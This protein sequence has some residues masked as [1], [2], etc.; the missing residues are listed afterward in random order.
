MFELCYTS[1]PKGLAPGSSGYTTVGQSPQMRIMHVKEA[2]R[3][4]SFQF[5]NV[6]DPRAF[7]REPVNYIHLQLTI[8]KQKVHIVSRIAACQPDHTGRSNY[9]AHHTL[10][11]RQEAQPCTAG[12]AQLAAS[13]AFLMTEWTGDARILPPR[14]LP[15][16]S[17]QG[18]TDNAIKAAGLDPGWGPVLADRLCDRGIKQTYLVY[19]LG[20]DMLGIVVDVL[21]NLTPEE[22]WQATF[23][24][25][26]TKTFPPLGFDCRLRC[27][28]ADT[29]YAKEVL[30]RFPKDTIDLSKHP[31]APP[32][33]KRSTIEFDDEQVRPTTSDKRKRVVPDGH[34]TITPP[35]PTTDGHWHQPEGKVTIPSTVLPP[36]IPQQLNGADRRGQF[37]LGAILIPSVLFLLMSIACVLLGYKWMQEKNLYTKSNQQVSRLEKKNGELE[38]ESR[39]QL[40][41]IKQLKESREQL[42][43]KLKEPPEQPEEPENKSAETKKTKTTKQ[44]DPS[45]HDEEPQPEKTL[46]KVEKTLPKV[47]PK[48]TSDI[49]DDNDTAHSDKPVTDN[50]PQVHKSFHDD[51]K[52][53]LNGEMKKKT[54]I[55]LFE[56]VDKPSAVTVTSTYDDIKIKAVGNKHEISVK[57]D[58]KSL[59]ICNIACDENISVEMSEKGKPY[60]A[61]FV[62]LNFKFKD[63]RE[64]T[65]PL[66]SP[67]DSLLYVDLPDGS[68]KDDAYLTNEQSYKL[69]KDKEVNDL[70]SSLQADFQ[71]YNREILV[72]SFEFDTS[73]PSCSYVDP[74]ETSYSNHAQF[75]FKTPRKAVPAYSIG[76]GFKNRDG[77]EYEVSSFLIDPISYTGFG[78][79]D[80]ELK[81]KT[82]FTEGQ[83]KAMTNV[84][85]K[86]E[87]LIQKKQ[88]KLLSMGLTVG[89]KTRTVR[90]KD[91]NDWNENTAKSTKLQDA[92]NTD[93]AAFADAQSFPLSNFRNKKVR[94]TL[95]VPDS[96]KEFVI[97][98]SLGE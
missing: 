73:D 41:E 79:C 98:D 26:A 47:L 50:G 42:E 11:S 56:N 38:S 94:F 13:H 86:Q 75:A 52:E 12:P 27:V 54:S 84:Y 31:A 1:L 81:G 23:V 49:P 51:M 69:F 40:K 76:V 82:I 8:D 35:K 66:G 64:A 3:L 34:S 83:I 33:Q 2:E 70:I 68:G 43:K 92:K 28:V 24:T 63:G 21:S 57:I 71:K 65:V 17:N 29:P 19:S 4:S 96:L 6:T 90:E 77:A 16:I 72:A 15:A 87:Q 37:G 22:R 88:D 91:L 9:F 60:L 62:T 14:D 89:L 44:K 30:S 58:G 80:K 46:P 18:T 67:F 20:T 10:L 78:F 32:R 97:V 7:S 85:V 95:K 36:Y 39:G 25:H 48:T 53:Y 5:L 55:L 93:A 74:A 59:A 45:G 61:R